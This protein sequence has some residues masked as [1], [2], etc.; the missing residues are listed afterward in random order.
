M[1]V[2]QRIQKSNQRRW[3]N[4]LSGRRAIA[5]YLLASP[6]LLGLTL[7][8]AYPMLYAIYISFTRWRVIGGS[9]W[10]GL[11]NY[12]RMLSDPM[13]V[14]SLKVTA[15]YTALAV[16]LRLLVG[17]LMAFLLNQRVKG[18]SVFRTVYYAPSVLSGPAIAILWI[19]TQLLQKLNASRL[20]SRY[21]RYIWV[22]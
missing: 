7:L 13:V 18:V 1:T 12:K 19:Y 17:F 2:A 11:D 10:I 21:A 15:T 22:G 5:G 20:I 16:P 8:F 4:T 9:A 3:W 14:H 6:W